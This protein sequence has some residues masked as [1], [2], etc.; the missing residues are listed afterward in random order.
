MA[1]IV[2]ELVEKR[3]LYSKH[4]LN[5][6]GTITAEI[7]SSPIHYKTETREYD[8]ID[9]TIIPEQNWEFEYAL[10][11]SAFRAYFND[12]T[13]I[14]NFTLA[15]FELINSQG[16]S[17]WVTFKMLDA[18]PTDSSCE[19]N[20]FKYHNVFPNVDL[21]Y[22]VTPEKLKE[23]IIVHDPSALR[24]FTFTL[25]LD[26]GLEM[27]VQPNN[28]IH[29]IDKETGETLW[30]IQAPFAID[31][32][33]EQKRTDNVI[34][35]FGKAIYQD[36]EY[37]T[38]TVEIQDD[39][40]LANAAYPIEIDPT[41]TIQPNET[42]G[43]DTTIDTRV[44]TRNYGSDGYIYFGRT[45][46]GHTYRALLKFDVSSIPSNAIVIDASLS[47]YL[48]GSLDN[49]TNTFA[50]Y[51][52]T[53]N[54]DELSVTWD[55]QPNYDPATESGVQTYDRI[56]GWRTFTITNIVAAWVNGTKPNYGV[57]LK[58]TNEGAFGAFGYVASENTSSPQNRPK[59]TITY[60]LPPT[61]PTVTAPNGGEMWNAQ[62]TITWNPS[63]DAETA[64]GS[65]QYHIQLSTNNGQT[66]KDIV[67]LTSP[68]ATSYTYD[69]TN[70]PATNQAKVRIR[71]Y[72]G[73]SYSTWDE[74]NGVF[75]IVHKVQIGTLKVQASS[76]TLTIPIYD[77][78]V[79]M[80]GKNQLRIQTPRGVGCFELVPTTDPNA[81]PLRIYTP[82]GVKA[83]AKQ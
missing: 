57:M 6:D 67:A 9:L 62:H 26:A 66:W 82:S 42:N 14:E 25:K 13:D 60:N 5:N 3:D 43:I 2:R 49:V 71:A 79:G 11:K 46:Y 69:F 48:Y 18:T 56:I 68:G 75:T 21:E 70:E 36:V 22:T 64:R 47:L 72:D 4:Y 27:Q 28:D 81:S 63:T 33:E 32:G 59:L 76:G 53:Q 16:V 73:I 51:N 38:I 20:R 50:A 1:E 61:A 29:F 23:N 30:K 52:I 35:T 58:A 24:P 17:R 19:G 78:N 8:D 31:S 74:S 77:P 15:G 55:T 37:D 83:I 34:Y 7:H 54:W 10:K 80:T 41:V 39:D 44:R 12:V 40:F 65:L 45:D